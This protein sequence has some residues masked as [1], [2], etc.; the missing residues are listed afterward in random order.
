MGTL[1]R[2]VIF[3]ITFAVLGNGDALSSTQDLVAYSR[4][5]ERLLVG[6]AGALSLWLGYRLFRVVGEASTP[7][8]GPLTPGQAGGGIEGNIGK[9]VRLKMWDVG[10]GLFFAL[11]GSCLLAYLL[12]SDVKIAV[13][14]GQSDKAEVSQKTRTTIKWNIPGL[15][16]E[17]NSE[18]IAAIVRAI[19]SLQDVGL[20]ADASSSDAKN[21]QANAITTLVQSIP[22]LV[23]AGF[24]P[25]AY[26]IYERLKVNPSDREK[27]SDADRQ[28]FDA[29]SAT[30]NSGI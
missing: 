3:V 26:A 10:P 19:R 21:R 15:T 17:Q 2:I 11:F 22:Q 14:T 9:Y 1:N 8:A 12:F 4:V 6:L 18:R 28:K 30:V 20:S 13:E 24:G 25:G 5:G 16:P 29:V 23:D 7:L 27:A